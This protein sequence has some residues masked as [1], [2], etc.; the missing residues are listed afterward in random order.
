MT[1]TGRS[2]PNQSPASYEVQ[3]IRADFPIFEKP[4][5]EKPLIYLDNAATTQ[6]PQ[7]VVNAVTEYYLKTCSSVHRGIH[8]L[9]EL[10]TELYEGSRSKVQHFIHAASPREIVFVRGATEG[11]NLVAHSYGRIHLEPGCEILITAMEHHSNIVPWQMLCKE[12]GARLRI[13]PIS[14]AG[15]LQIEQYEKMLNPKTRLVAVTHVSNVLGTINPV[16]NLIGLA[17]GRNIPVLVDGAQAVPHMPV[18]VQELDCDFYVF[19]GHKIYG[20]TGI[21]VLYGKERL[22]NS[23]SPY[24]GGGEMISSVTYSDTVFNNPPHRFEAGT[25]NIAGAIGLGAAIDYLDSLGLKN[26]LAHEKAL[27]DYGIRALR[28]LDGLRIIGT[29]EEKTGVLS[30]TLR[31]AH[32][33]DIGTILNEDG[34]AIRTGHQCAQPLMDFFKIP[35]AARVSFALYNTREDIDALFLSLKKVLEV[36]P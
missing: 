19:S 7:A 21:G 13:A 1:I 3:K 24:Q 26:I 9:S 8:S 34:I 25:P 36:L 14:S 6:K 31:S 35:A 16:R 33:H 2:A 4:V 12:K 28:S 30:F 17:H 20:P 22:L 29:A 18:D 27:L 32:P 23:M 5:K 15:E 10:S 11:I